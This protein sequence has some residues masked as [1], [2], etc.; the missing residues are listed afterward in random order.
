MPRPAGAGAVRLTAMNVLVTGGAGYIGSVTVAAL[1]GAGH[2]VVVLDDLST[3]HRAAVPDGVPFVHAS[4][5]DADMVDFA[6]RHH[7][8]TAV[9][10][11]A[12]ASLVGE[13][14]AQPTKYF[15]AN[16]AGTFA[17]LD[18]AVKRGVER[19]VLSSTAA[20][21]G[22]PHS[23]PIAEAAELRPES[24]YGESKL[25]IERALGWLARTTGLAST[26][27]RYFNAAGATAELG[28][29]HRPETHLVPL[30]LQ[31]AAGRRDAIQVFGTDYPTPDGT[32]IRD[33]VHV[34]DLAAAH[35]LAL[36]ALERGGAHAYNLGSGAG[37]SVREVI[38]AC[39]R[40]T[41]AAIREV[42]VGRRAGDP[43]VL[44]ADSSKARAE[45]GWEPRHEDLGAI[46]GSAWQ[47]HR[48]NP[49]GYEGR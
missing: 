45:L 12:A 48:A 5:A 37:W 28:E 47:W 11:F 38:E 29:D 3:G 16:T 1:V 35:V 9:V 43:P 6:L 10:H 27:L 18:V 20:V 4:V 46:V 49:G 40:V 39:R 41:G 30:V 15:L 17:L 36:E 33:Y 23:V 2:D 42:E 32:A 21:Y 26:A 34:S 13:S 8:V 14:M 19:F 24:V 31:V 44:V 7:G 22:T 25:M